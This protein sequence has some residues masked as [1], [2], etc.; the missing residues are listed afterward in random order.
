MSVSDKD[1]DGGNSGGVSFHFGGGSQ[2]GGEVLAD[3]FLLSV[4]DTEGLYNT[5]TAVENS[6][7]GRVK[8]ALAQ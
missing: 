1:A 4:E 6:S 3:W 5:A 8:A 2:I 7:W